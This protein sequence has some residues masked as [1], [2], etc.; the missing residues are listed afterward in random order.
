MKNKINKNKLAKVIFVCAIPLIMSSCSSTS[1]D[2]SDAPSGR[3]TIDAVQGTATVQSVDTASRTVVLR[4]SD[5]T[6]TSYECGP[7]VRN[8][9]QI[10]VGDT[11][12]ATMAE[13]VAVALVKGGMEPAAGSTS[14]VVT[15]PLGAKPAG[16][17][18]D[19]VGFTAKVTGIDAN[20][21][22]VMLQTMDGK[23]QTV[24]VEPDVDLTKINVG[25]SVGVRITRAF[26]I[27]V[28]SPTNSNEQSK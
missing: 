5:G 20:D 22:M 27:A 19:T 14:A 8:F 4:H 7:E 1:S 17:M 9:D 25:D 6:T 26:A 15:A 13:S 21:R 28:T 10:K 3:V 24:K 11:V 23:N 18:V 2:Y 16:K 12:T